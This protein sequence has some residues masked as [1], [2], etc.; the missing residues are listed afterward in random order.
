MTQ[1]VKDEFML[2]IF[3]VLYHSLSENFL[4]E[5]ISCVKSL[6]AHPSKKE[7]NANRLFMRF[8]FEY[9][10]HHDPSKSEPWGPDPSFTPKPL[11]EKRKDLQS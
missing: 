3:A 1:F 9:A 5:V 6:D 4:T 11:K 10:R 8:L 7:S 2:T